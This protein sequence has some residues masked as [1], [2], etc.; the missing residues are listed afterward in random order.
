MSE[1]QTSERPSTRIGGQRQPPMP[2]KE[3]WD[4]YPEGRIAVKAKDRCSYLQLA[5]QDH[6]YNADQADPK[7]AAAAP[8]LPLSWNQL[9]SLNVSLVF[10]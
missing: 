2:Q 7:K 9:S 5:H 1:I 8:H 6:F 10:R 4:R 3:L